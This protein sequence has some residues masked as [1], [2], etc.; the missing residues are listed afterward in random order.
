MLAKEKIIGDFGKIDIL[1]NCAGGNSPKATTGVEMLLDSDEASIDD[2]FFGLDFENFRNVTD[3]NLLGT[4]LPSV[5]F[6]RD[7]AKKSKGNPQHLF[8][9][10]IQASYKIPAYSVSKAA[11]NNITQWLA[12]HLAKVNIRVNAIAPGFFHHNAKRI[13]SHKK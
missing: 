8:N 1:I 10:G 13:S 3:L 6:G 7:M 2:F 12:A 4:V 11:V 9:D 5:V